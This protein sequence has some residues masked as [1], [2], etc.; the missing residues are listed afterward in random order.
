MS[1]FEKEVICISSRGKTLD[2]DLDPHFNTCPYFL[3]VKPGK[4]EIKVIPNPGSKDNET[5]VGLPAAQTV[6]KENI[7]TLLT[8]YIGP[9]A[10]GAL[11]AYGVAFGIG[12]MDMSCQRALN[13]FQMKKLELI[14]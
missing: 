12:L 9:K 2:S 5:G 10:F 14:K 3:I 7:T 1:D 13:Q 11:E 4:D 8:G 6:L